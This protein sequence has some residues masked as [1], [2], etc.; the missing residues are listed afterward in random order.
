MQ[1]NVL[2]VI[3]FVVWG[4]WQ[5]SSACPAQYTVVA[6]AMDYTMQLRVYYIIE[7]Y[8]AYGSHLLGNECI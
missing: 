1:E 2:Q 4:M 6:C 3:I 7:W 5:I 8:V